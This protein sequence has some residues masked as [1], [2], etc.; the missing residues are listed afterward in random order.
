MK[1]LN[2]LLDDAASEAPDKTAYV[3]TSCVFPCAKVTFGDL[4]RGV[5]RAA[6]GFEAR[7]GKAG[8]CVAIVHRNDP[9]FV[10][11]YLALNRLGAIAVPLNFMVQ[12]ADE[13]AYMLND[14]K[15]VGIVTQK[16]FL[17]GL[18]AAAEKT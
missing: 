11:S 17:R 4:R 8:D 3:T 16:E 15:A 18:R 10:E 5:L 7:G 2:D 6:A 13:L 14:C 1:T 12:K 9:V